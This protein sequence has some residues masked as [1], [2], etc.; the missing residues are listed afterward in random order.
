MFVQAFTNDFDVFLNL[1]K[2]QNVSIITEVTGSQQSDTDRI[3]VP[4]ESF[5]K[6]LVGDKMGGVEFE[7]W[8]RL[9]C[10]QEEA[11]KMRTMSQIL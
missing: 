9:D 11:G 4:V 1:S 8:F 6:A 3:V 7:I 5:S 2:I 10:V